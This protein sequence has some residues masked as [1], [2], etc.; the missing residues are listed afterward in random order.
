[1]EIGSLIYNGEGPLASALKSDPSDRQGGDCECPSFKNYPR[2]LRARKERR[3]RA[4]RL[5]VSETLLGDFE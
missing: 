1:L 3:K 5:P 2:D 4:I